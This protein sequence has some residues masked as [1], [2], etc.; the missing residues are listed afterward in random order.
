MLLHQRCNKG[1]T[2]HIQAA[3]SSSTEIELPVRLAF[4]LSSFKSKKPFCEET[5]LEVAP[6]QLQGVASSN[7]G[8][9]SKIGGFLFLDGVAVRCCL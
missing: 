3:K 4:F 8:A 1:G 7:M 6:L 2:V 9:E 5:I